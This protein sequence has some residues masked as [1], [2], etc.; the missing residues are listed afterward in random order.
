MS[1]MSLAVA[2]KTSSLLADWKLLLLPAADLR[3]CIRNCRISMIISRIPEL[4][5][6]V[7]LIGVL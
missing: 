5:L 1:E 4:C 3:P 6:A 2:V 7:A